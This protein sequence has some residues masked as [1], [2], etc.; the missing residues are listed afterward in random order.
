MTPETKA[1]GIVVRDAVVAYYLETCKSITV[2][3]L[4]PRLR[5]S[6]SK[7]RRVFDEHRGS[8]DGITARHEVRESHE[9]NYDS[10]HGAHKAWV[11]QPALWELRRR[12]LEATKVSP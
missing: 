6:E 9:R 8:V 7:L 3:E 1:A 5:W 11:Y 10:V 12:L 2:K 4:A